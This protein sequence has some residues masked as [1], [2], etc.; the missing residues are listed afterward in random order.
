LDLGKLV[1]EGGN[2]PVQDIDEDDIP[3]VPIFIVILVIGGVGVGIMSL[4]N[5]AGNED[6]DV[7]E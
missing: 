2:S 4:K 3:W 5:K 6:L 7:E 1:I